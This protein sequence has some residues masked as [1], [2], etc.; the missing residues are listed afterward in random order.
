MI[1][2]VLIARGGFG[3]I[4]EPAWVRALRE[5]G[6]KAELFDAHALTL[7]GLAGRLERRL[8]WGPGIHRIN[9]RLIEQVKTQRPDL[10]LLYQGHY[11]PAAT[12]EQLRELT[13]V[14]GCH[15]D[16]PF[17]DRKSLLR[18]RH[19][20]PALPYYHGFHVDSL[21]HF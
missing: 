6:V 12:I 2:S 13:F 4:Y 15:N 10:L 7:P 20:L 8:L 14:V 17:G 21:Q 16:D 1:Q 18:Y 5:L 11:Y 3:E 9:Q 19:L